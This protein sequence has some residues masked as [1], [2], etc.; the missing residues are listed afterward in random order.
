MI[1]TVAFHWFAQEKNSQGKRKISR[2]LDNLGLNHRSDYALYPFESPAASLGADLSRPIQ[3]T[4][5]IIPAGTKQ[6]AGQTL[7]H[8]PLSPRNLRSPLWEK[9]VTASAAPRSR[10]M[11][12]CRLRSPEKLTADQRRVLPRRMVATTLHVHA[13]EEHI[14][15]AGASA[16]FGG[17]GGEQ[18]HGALAARVH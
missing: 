15:P 1:P 13:P 18:T 5:R 6:L 14:S 8:S 3:W 11:A 16:T 2:G 17:D 4:V 10:S 7:P 12:A 9:T